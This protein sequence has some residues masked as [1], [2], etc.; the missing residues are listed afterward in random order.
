MN[1]IE[2]IRAC[3]E[4]TTMTKKKNKKMKE[5]RTRIAEWAY[6]ITIRLAVAKSQE[7]GGVALALENVQKVKQFANLD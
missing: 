7:L 6:V 1:F 2:A 3:S 4:N 5:R